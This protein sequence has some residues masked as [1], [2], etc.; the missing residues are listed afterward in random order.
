[1]ARKTQFIGLTILLMIALVL[2]ISDIRLV[3]SAGTVYIREDG[4]IDP[5][6]A[7]IST[8]DNIT[9]TLTDNIIDSIVIERGDIILDGA[10][11][12]LEGDGTGSGVRQTGLNN[13]TIR[14]LNINGFYFGIY[15]ENASAC[16]ILNSNI[17]AN[18]Y[19][20]I[21]LLES[22]QNTISLNNVSSNG[23]DGIKLWN[24]S[25]GNIV[26]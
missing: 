24:S 21:Y 6:T 23:N 16:S 10:G 11:F 7:T 25:W 13:I 12:M 19:D 5:P 1:M 3:R 17:T 20:G 18:I 22:P 8:I 9:Y 26:S 15:L 14:N 2:C 4:S